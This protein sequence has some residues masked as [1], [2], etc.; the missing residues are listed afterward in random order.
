MIEDDPRWASLFSPDLFAGKTVFVTGGGSGINFGIARGF[1]GLGANV[2]ICGRDRTKLDAAV[3]ALRALGAQAAGFQADVRDKEAVD[4]ALQSSGEQFGPVDVLVCGA[5]GN[6]MCPAEDLSSNGF[7]AVV[8]IDLV[9]SFHA[10]HAAFAQLK[11]T[12]GSIL[13][14]S[15]G[16]AFQPFVHQV[17]VGAAKAG[18]DNMMRNLAYEWGRFGIR[19]NSIAPGF[20]AD[21]EGTRRMAADGLA[22][23]LREATP[24]GR[25][26]SVD[27]IAAMALF[28]AS[29]L[30][31]YV[32]GG[33][34]V[35]DG[36]H[37]LG[38]SGL[39]RSHIH[40]REPAG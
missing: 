10:A 32:T 23:R 38:G 31:A 13:F 15:A 11:S 6:F 7:R 5:A 3:A 4:V 12:R 21:T 34:F 24:L 29:P 35:V 40:Q 37:Y 33:V 27:D 2:A 1:A 20:I 26:G 17:H 18:I 30:A 9:G 36:G 19:S 14:I 39:F 28:L 16:Q 22:D 8:D 25:L